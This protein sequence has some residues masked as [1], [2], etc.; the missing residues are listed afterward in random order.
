MNQFT[1]WFE[2]GR[3]CTSDTF[4]FVI[5]RCLYISMLSLIDLASFWRY[6]K[7]LDIVSGFI[8]GSRHG[9]DLLRLSSLRNSRYLFNVINNRSTVLAGLWGADNYMDKDMA[10]KK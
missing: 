5:D 7:T 4:E 9:T 2:H 6:W 1:F 10:H 3:V 8:I